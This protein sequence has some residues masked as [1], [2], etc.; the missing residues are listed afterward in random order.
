M[1]AEGGTFER[2]GKQNRT[3]HC[4]NAPSNGERKHKTQGTRGM[5]ENIQRNTTKCTDDARQA[6]EVAVVPDPRALIRRHSHSL[7]RAW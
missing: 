1:A 4:T 3:N 2:K 7:R 6:V 5:H